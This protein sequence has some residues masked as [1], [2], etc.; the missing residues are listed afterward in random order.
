MINNYS[1]KNI[2]HN[3][4]QNKENIIS[5]DTSDEE[6]DTDLGSDIDMNL[7]EKSL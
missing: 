1:T 2:N 6:D 3:T 4:K 7:F 5:L